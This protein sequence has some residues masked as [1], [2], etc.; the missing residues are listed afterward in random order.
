MQE[1][2]CPI[3]HKKVPPECTINSEHYPFCGQRC[4]LIDLGRW[5]SNDYVIPSEDPNEKGSGND[6]QKP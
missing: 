2:F 4:H 3:C 1:G 6:G 5:L